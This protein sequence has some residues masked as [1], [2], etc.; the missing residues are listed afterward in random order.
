[1]MAMSRVELAMVWIFHSKFIDQRE[2]ILFDDMATI[3]A[4]TLFRE[5]RVGNNIGYVDVLTSRAFKFG[6]LLLE[7]GYSVASNDR[8]KYT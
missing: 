2:K 8:K 6:E 1:M 7:I 3:Y 5:Q 4:E